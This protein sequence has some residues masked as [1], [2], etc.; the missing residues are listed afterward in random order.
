MT[1]KAVVCVQT[2]G[3]EEYDVFFRYEGG[4]LE[5]GAEL[6]NAVRKTGRVEQ[7][8][9]KVGAGPLDKCVQD[10]EIL[11]RNILT[12]RSILKQIKENPFLKKLKSK[13]GDLLIKRTR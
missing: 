9:K 3:A 10:I 7:A 5:L 8:V 12:T 6:L 1:V 11:C 2:A 4:P 13:I